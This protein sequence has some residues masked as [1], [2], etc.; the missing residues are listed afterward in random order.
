LDKDISNLTPQEF[1]DTVGNDSSSWYR[2]SWALL[3][4]ADAVENSCGQMPRDPDNEE[5]V[6]KWAEVHGVARMLRGMALECMFKALWIEH[7]GSLVSKGK[8]KGIPGTKD[9]DL[10]SLEA[11]VAEKADTGLNTEE[12]RLLAR[13][14]FFIEFGRYPIRK[15]ISAKY[16]SSPCSDKPIRWCLWTPEKD[17]LFNGIMEK[18]SRLFK[19]EPKSFSQSAI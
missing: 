17:R 15:S 12:K 9:H 1:F 8:Y 13:L 5:E 3:C 6:V 4:S 14:S 19:N 18:L 11:K 2:K 10:C 16:P 7:G